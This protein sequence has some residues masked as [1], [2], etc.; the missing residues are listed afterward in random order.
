M[1]SQKLNIAVLRNMIK[2]ER[3]G[4]LSVCDCCGGEWEIW[5]RKFKV[6]AINRTLFVERNFSHKEHRIKWRIEIWK[7]S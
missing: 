1:Q 6:R 2:V 7:R 4:G 3:F 5:G